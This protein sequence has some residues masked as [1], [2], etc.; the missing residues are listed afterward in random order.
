MYGR[1]RVARELDLLLRR[2]VGEDLLLELARLLLEPA[3]LGGEVDRLGR[4]AAELADL[5]LEVDDRPL[6]LEDH[7]VRERRAVRSTCAVA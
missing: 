1:A 5:P 7:A 2:E 3:D 4:Q 6:E